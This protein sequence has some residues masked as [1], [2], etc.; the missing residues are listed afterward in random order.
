MRL[1]LLFVLALSP[2]HAS[3]SQWTRLLLEQMIS[4]IGNAPMHNVFVPEAQI[5]RKLEG[6]DTISLVESCSEADII[7]TSQ[8]RPDAGCA[9]KP[10]I[11]LSYRAFKTRSDAIGA[12]F[13]QKGRPTVVYSRMRLDAFGLDVNES[14]KKYIVKKL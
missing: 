1:L 7:I 5:R 12:F 6:L 9:L 3:E 8:A 10:T 14:V 11:V 2:L 4:S 13:W